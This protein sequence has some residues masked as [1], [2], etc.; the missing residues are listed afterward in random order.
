MILDVHLSEWTVRER[1][2]IRIAASPGHTLAAARAVTRR[3]VRMLRFLMALRSLPVAFRRGAQRGLDKPLLRGFERMGFAEL[4]ESSNEFV[5]GGVGRFWQPSGGLRQ[6][7]AEEFAGFHEPGYAK[8]GFNFQVEP[9]GNGG[10]V[11]STETRVLAT[12]DHARRRFRLY[13]TFVRPGSGLI[14]HA[15]LHAIRS[16]A[17]ALGD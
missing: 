5:Y 13:W 12:D 2:S 16:R 3:E 15:W 8:A 10:C 14:R 4:G 17:E 9:D 11:L 1:H 7:S 6:V